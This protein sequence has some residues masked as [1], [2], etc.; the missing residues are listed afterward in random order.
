MANNYLILETYYINTCPYSSTMTS[1]WTF[2]AVKEPNGVTSLS[3]PPPS[4]FNRESFRRNSES[5][6]PTLWQSR[7]GPAK[8]CSVPYQVQDLRRNKDGSPQR[9]LDSGFRRT[10]GRCLYP[11]A[12][13]R[14]GSA[15]VPGFAIPGK[16]LD[17]SCYPAELESILR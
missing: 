6:N 12:N 13:R 7:L 9:F 14:E 16:L 3:Q 17:A 10:D 5:R 8:R 15:T 1:N 4:C 2:V 11:L